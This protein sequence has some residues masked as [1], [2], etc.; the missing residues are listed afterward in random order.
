MVKKS[1]LSVFGMFLSVIGVVGVVFSQFMVE[2]FLSVIAAMS[3][4]FTLALQ[5][6]EK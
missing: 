2:M 1:L 4:L 6:D 5:Y 3:G